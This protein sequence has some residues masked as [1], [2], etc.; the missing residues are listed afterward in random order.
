MRLFLRFPKYISWLGDKELG[1]G[2]C[3]IIPLSSRFF[4]HTREGGLACHAL[5]CGRAVVIVFKLS[6]NLLLEINFI[7]V[8]I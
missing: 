3:Y 4:R 5:L 2:I 8:S 6:P 7:S 1:R